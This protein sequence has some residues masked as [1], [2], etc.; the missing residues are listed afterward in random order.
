MA[1]YPLMNTTNYKLSELPIQINTHL[2]Y[3]MAFYTMRIYQ[4]KFQEQL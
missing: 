4:L 3:K 1:K 2:Y